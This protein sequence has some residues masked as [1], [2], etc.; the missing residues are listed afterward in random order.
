VDVGSRPDAA[1][2]ANAAGTGRA[3]SGPVFVVAMENQDAARIYGNSTDAPYINGTLLPQYAHATAFADALPTLPSEPHYIW[4]EAG[5][6]AFADHTFT[7]DD[8]PSAKNITGS[9]DHLVAQIAARGNL[10]WMSYQEGIGP[11]TGACPI[12][13]AGFYRPRHHPFVYFRD[14]AGDPPSKDTAACAAHHRELGALASDLASG[15]VADY[16]FISPNLCHDM[17][18]ATGCP[19]SNRTRAGDDWLA[20]NL[21]ALIDFVDANDGVIFVTWEEAEHTATVPFIAVGPRVKPGY[22]GGTPYT[23]GSMLKTVEQRLG[24]PI[25]PAAASATDLS[26]LF[27]R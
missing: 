27:A 15:D 16:S 8:S 4:M 26:D 12:A 11:A 18:G 7:T 17:H 1:A 3:V 5:T 9:G 2:N 14:V 25:L 23:H 22:A 13:G 24:L 6:N 19:S 21:P 20:A 10:N